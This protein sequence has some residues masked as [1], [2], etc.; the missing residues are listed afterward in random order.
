MPFFFL[1]DKI[2]RAKSHG[3]NLT[4]KISRAKMDTHK[5]YPYITERAAS[6]LETALHY[7][8]ESGEADAL[9]T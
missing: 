4:G 7:L 1:T 5:G 2:S 6:K 9:L 8:I 3:Q